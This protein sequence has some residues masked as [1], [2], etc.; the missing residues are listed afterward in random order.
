MKNNLFTAVL[1]LALMPAIACA[2]A[3][4]KPKDETID[5]IIQ[6]LGIPMGNSSLISNVLGLQARPRG[7]CDRAR[8][9]PSVTGTPL[10]VNC[11]IDL[12]LLYPKV[13]DATVQIFVRTRGTVLIGTAFKLCHDSSKQCFYVSSLHVAEVENYVGVVAAD[14]KTVQYTQVVARNPAKDLMLLA[15]PDG[16]VRP[17]LKAGSP[18]KLNDSAFMVG[19]P[20]G[21]PEDVIT[22]GQI[23]YEKATGSATLPQNGQVLTINDLFV[24]DAHVLEGNSGG[25]AFNAAGE[26]IGIDCMAFNA[27]KTLPNGGAVIV[28]IAEATN[29]M[30]ELVTSNKVTK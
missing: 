18:P 15:V 21:F 13:K 24:I 28:P 7:A 11:G 14:K 10:Q 12:P 22:A 9:A 6:E 8:Q 20:Y 3:P 23:A 27:S 4:T 29:L 26:V 2:Q 19:H 30:D 25:P 1:A 17:S 16:D 5:P